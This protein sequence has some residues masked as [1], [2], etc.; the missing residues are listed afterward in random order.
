M[1]TVYV[2]TFCLKASTLIKYIFVNIP[3]Q[4]KN[5]RSSPHS[6]FLQIFSAFPRLA[7]LS[8]HCV[9]VSKQS[10]KIR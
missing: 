5:R 6:N 10:K 2:L 7:K 4:I 9:T 3:T 8:V 1:R